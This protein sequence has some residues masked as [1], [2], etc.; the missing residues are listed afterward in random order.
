MR[1]IHSIKKSYGCSGEDMESKLIYTISERD[2]GKKI[3]GYLKDNQDLSSRLVRSAAK[4]ERVRVNGSIVRM[5]YI[6]KLGDTIEI[7]LNKDESQDIEPQP[8]DLDVV[9]EDSDILVVNKPPF[10]VVH[11]TKSYPDNTLANGV[12]HYFKASGQNC[13]VRL[14]SRLDM[15]TSGL[16]IIAKNQFSHMALA[17]EML[18]EDFEKS[19]LAIVHGNLMDKKGTIDKPIFRPTEDSIK[20]T[21]DDRGQ[22]SITHFEVVES[23][24]EAELVKLTLETG[25]THQIRVHLS[26]LG[27][28]IFGDNLYCDTNDEEYIERQALHAYKL[29]FPNPRT[30]KRIDL[31][32]QMPEDMKSL[33][34]KLKY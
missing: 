30:G 4:E 28:P 22:R 19:Y 11:P 34:E 7:D 3:R 15:N 1:K 31:E 33:L 13:I 20:R 12:L 17:R 25:R 26:H 18:K 23:F 9:Y 10:M 8:M 24:K 14:V 29:S 21:V 32:A 16:I 5:N 27:N 6:L 2:E